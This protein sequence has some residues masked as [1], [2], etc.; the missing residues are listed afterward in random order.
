MRGAVQTP[1][2]WADKAE[3]HTWLRCRRA[4]LAGL[5]EMTP[6]PRFYLDASALLKLSSFEWRKL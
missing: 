5:V 6:W 3:F 1:A 4:M 2:H